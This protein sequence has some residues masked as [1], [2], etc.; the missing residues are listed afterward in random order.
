MGPSEED[1]GNECERGWEAGLDLK[2]VDGESET[3]PDSMAKKNTGEVAVTFLHV[4]QG[5]FWE[6]KQDVTLCPLPDN[7][8]LLT[9]QLLTDHEL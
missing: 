1:K 5:G 9:Q 2:G 6:G 4:A 7:H 3:D 8:I